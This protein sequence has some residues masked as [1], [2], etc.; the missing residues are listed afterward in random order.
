MLHRLHLFHVDNT[1]IPECTGKAND[2]VVVYVTQYRCICRK[3]L[4]K[5]KKG[6]E[7]LFSSLGIFN[8][9]LP[10]CEEETAPKSIE[11]ILVQHAGRKVSFDVYTE[12]G[13]T[14]TSGTSFTLWMRLAA[15]TGPGNPFKRGDI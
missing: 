14:G 5:T 4:R 3:Q 15:V 8:A 11:L 2:E 1:V 12:F 7:Q 6:S 9:R 10:E 13:S